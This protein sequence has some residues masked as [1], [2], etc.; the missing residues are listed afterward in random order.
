MYGNMRGCILKGRVLLDSMF[1][2]HFIDPDL[3]IEIFFQKDAVAENGGL[4]FEKWDVGT[5]AHFYWRLKKISWRVSAFSL[6]FWWKK[7]AL[8]SSL[9]L[10]FHPLII[11]LFFLVTVQK[12]V[13]DASRAPGGKWEG[14][15]RKLWS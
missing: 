11:E 15:S 2:Y 1:G 8:K 4:D 12:A 5:S 13:V 7:I 6:I 10:Y 9:D 3:R 14:V